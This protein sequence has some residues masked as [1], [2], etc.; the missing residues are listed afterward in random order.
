MTSFMDDNTHTTNRVFSISKAKR[1]YPFPQKISPVIKS[2]PSPKKMAPL[3]R[4]LW[5]LGV[6]AL[7][8][9]VL[10]VFDPETWGSK[11]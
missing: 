11:L 3:M 1:C 8:V 9:L 7:R 2:D 4:R 10:D 5:V 6:F